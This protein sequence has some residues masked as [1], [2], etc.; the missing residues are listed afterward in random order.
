MSAASGDRSP[1]ESRRATGKTA[2]GEITRR[3]LLGGGAATLAGWLAWPRLKSIGAAKA[4]VFFARNQRYDGPLEQTLAD[5]LRAVG[6][7]PAS[8]AGRRVLLK[9]N[10]VEPSRL[11]PHMTTHPAMIVAAAHVFRSWGAHVTVGEGPGHVRDT[12]L[13]LIESGV[14]A[15]LDDAGL[16]FADLNYEEVEW[17]PNL[18]RASRLEGFWFPRSVVEADLIVSMPKMKTH[19]WVG[20]TGGSRTCMA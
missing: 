11:T 3:A 6:V 12:E 16:D 20:F 7:A 8:L 5:G 19:H 13:A 18:G 17:R 14:Q 1:L 10:L 9:P 4:P 15:A 2:R